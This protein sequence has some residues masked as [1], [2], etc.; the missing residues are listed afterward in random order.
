MDFFTFFWAAFLGAWSIRN[1]KKSWSFPKNKLQSPELSGDG[2][3][4]QRTNGPTDGRRD[5]SSYRA[6]ANY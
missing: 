3:S 1:K 5:T 6:V 4:D 2:Q